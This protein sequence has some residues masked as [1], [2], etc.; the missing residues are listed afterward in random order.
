MSH[1]SYD[2]TKTHVSHLVGQ[3]EKGPYKEYHEETDKNVVENIS[4]NGVVENGETR[5]I[6]IDDKNLF[7]P[8]IDLQKLV[9][10]EKQNGHQKCGTVCEHG[11]WGYLDCN[12]EYCYFIPPQTII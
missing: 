11:P 10:M 12:G 8:A 3:Y 1:K 2:V 7:I 4:R 5:R 6:G 9:I